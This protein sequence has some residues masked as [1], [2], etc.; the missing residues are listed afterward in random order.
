[1]TGAGKSQLINAFLGREILKSSPVAACT[2]TPVEISY[3]EALE[4]KVLFLARHEWKQEIVHLLDDI[5]EHRGTFHFDRKSPGTIAW[6]KIRVLYPTLTLEH[7][8]SNSMTADDILATDPDVEE[9]LGATKAIS[10]I[11]TTQFQEILALYTDSQLTA[12]RT[13]AAYWPI[14]TQLQITCPS[15]CLASGAILVDLPGGNDANP[16]RQ[17]VTDNYIFKCDLLWLVSPI[18]RAVSDDYMSKSLKTFWNQ[19][20]LDGQ[21]KNNR[22]TLIGIY[23]LL[24]YLNSYNKTICSHQE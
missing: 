13:T 18:V 21:Y 9:L 4:G 11:S 15:P 17:A 3:G 5:A 7:I 12:S 20:K 14:V 24:H 16:A 8:V 10:S 23:F 2:S 6:E 19:M 22:I 1:V